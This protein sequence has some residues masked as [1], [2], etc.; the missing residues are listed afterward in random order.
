MVGA[1][2]P[3]NAWPQIRPP[4]SKTHVRIRV[5]VKVVSAACIGSVVQVR[6]W[7]S[8]VAT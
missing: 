3:N 1:V 5:L 2:I 4:F 6:K 7:H 8:V